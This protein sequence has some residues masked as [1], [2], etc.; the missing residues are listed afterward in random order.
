MNST[1]Q[2]QSISQLF[3]VGTNCHPYRD[4]KFLKF[5]IS[6]GIVPVRPLLKERSLYEQKYV[7]KTFFKEKT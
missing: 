4:F 2:I 3:I 5:P 6:F 7:S 1:K